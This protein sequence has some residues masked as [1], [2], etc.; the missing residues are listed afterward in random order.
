[1]PKK[2]CCPKCKS[3]DLQFVETSYKKPAIPIIALLV[4]FLAFVIAICFCS[5]IFNLLPIET[6]NIVTEATI[7]KAIYSIFIMLLTFSCA[8]IFVLLFI[9][10]ETRREKAIK[11]VCCNCGKNDFLEK[12]AEKDSE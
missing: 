1:M 11:Y 2:I 12:I 6:E 8:I 5:Q 9:W 3:E 7:S 4:V 10:F